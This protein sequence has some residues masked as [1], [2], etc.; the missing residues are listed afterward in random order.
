[1]GLTGVKRWPVRE[2]VKLKCQSQD[3]EKGSGL[4][5]TLHPCVQPVIGYISREEGRMGSGVPL[6]LSH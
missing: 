5:L 4:P 6:S 3:L 2:E 1:M